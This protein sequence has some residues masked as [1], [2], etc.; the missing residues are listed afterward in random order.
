MRIIGLVGPKGSGKDSVAEILQAQGKVENKIS[1]AG[2]LKAICSDVFNLDLKLFNDPELKEKRLN[3]IIQ[4]SPYHLEAILWGCEDYIDINNGRHSVSVDDISGRIF[5]T[6]REILQV[7][8]TDFIRNKINERFHM[9]AS[10]SDKVISDLDKDKNYAVTDIRF[11]DEYVYL[12]QKFGNDFK[13]YYVR[14]PSAE[15]KLTSNSHSSE[16]ESQ[17]IKHLSTVDFIDNSG[18]LEDLEQLLKGFK[19]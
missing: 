2:P 19:V 10:F 3:E 15:A 17:R 11:M 12:A 7:I 1:F 4:V 9:E 14:R 18:S 6:P 16:L 13:C 8:G 5:S